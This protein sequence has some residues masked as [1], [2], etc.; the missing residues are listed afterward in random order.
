M[1]RVDVIENDAAARAVALSCWRAPSPPEPIGGG[2]TNRN[3]RVIDDGRVFVVRIGEDI[4]VHG[5]LRWH[6]AMVSR[7][8]HAAG[9]APRVYHH[10]PGALVFDYIDG[11]TLTEADVRDPDMLPRIVELVARCHRQV[12]QHLAGPVLSFWVFHVIRDYANRLRGAG[13]PYEPL[14]DGYLRQARLLEAATGRVDIVLGHNDLLAANI[15]DDG[16]RLWLVDWE[17]AGFN[18]PLFDLAGLATNNQLSQDQVAFMLARYFEEPLTNAIWRSFA[19]MKCASLM[20]ET[21]WSM[22]SEIHSDLDFDYAAYT[23]ENTAR[24][25]AALEDFENT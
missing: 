21:M 14:L 20:R 2:I 3:F 19:A 7:A 18:T 22:V 4:P 5:I 23:A 8:A 15:M 24:L 9:V 1:E 16:D 11:R 10:E 25:T 17:Y 6:E 13:S 12:P